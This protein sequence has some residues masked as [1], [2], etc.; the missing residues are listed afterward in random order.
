MPLRSA[1]VT[2][3]SAAVSGIERTMRSILVL[4]EYRSTVTAEHERLGRVA[5][6]TPMPLRPAR[7][8]RSTRVWQSLVTVAGN[9][10]G[11]AEHEY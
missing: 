3:Y 2:A 5:R 1:R 10:T 4:G 7:G 9:E 8:D 6:N 11:A